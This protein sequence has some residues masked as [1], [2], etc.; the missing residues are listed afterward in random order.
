MG[1]GFPGAGCHY[2]LLIIYPTLLNNPISSLVGIS[3]NNE[4]LT[5]RNENY[6]EWYN[7]VIQRAEMADYAPVRG[8][9]VITTLWLGS[10]GEYSTGTRLSIQGY[11]SCQCS[12]STLHPHVFP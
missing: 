9:M 6:S 5:P 12:L 11:R 8:C 7:Q 10:L 2:T 3:M 4:K 1:V